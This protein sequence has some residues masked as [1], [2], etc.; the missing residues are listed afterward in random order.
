[1]VHAGILI[2]STGWFIYAQ[3]LI[4][5]TVRFMVEGLFLARDCPGGM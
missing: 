4:M 3:G 2:V 5:H 1:M